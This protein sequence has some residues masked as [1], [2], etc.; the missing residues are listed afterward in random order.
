METFR[1]IKGVGFDECVQFQKIADKNLDLV[2]LNVV[3]EACWLFPA[4]GNK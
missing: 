3:S 4:A 2:D 1:H